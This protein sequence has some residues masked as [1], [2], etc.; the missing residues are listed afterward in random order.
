RRVADL[1]HHVAEGAVRIPRAAERHVL[2]REGVVPV[3][4]AAKVRDAVRR[5]AEVPLVVRLDVGRE[6]ER[7]RA[8]LSALEHVLVVV[9][10]PG[11]GD[12][13][14]AERQDERRDER[15]DSE[16]GPEEAAGEGGRAHQAA[17]WMRLS[18]FSTR[19]SR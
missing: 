16:A 13:E 3:V 10:V 2:E 15:R 1:E 5:V 6:L 18:P 7:G 9:R 12:A 4:E 11:L 8:L 17:M 19:T 14:P